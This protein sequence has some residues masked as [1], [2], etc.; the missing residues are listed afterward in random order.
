MK[1]TVPNVNFDINFVNTHARTL[2]RYFEP[3]AALVKSILIRVKPI[4][5]P[6]RPALVA[7]H[8]GILLVAEHDTFAGPT[9]SRGLAALRALGLLF[10]AFQLARAAC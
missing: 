6:R 4:K 5:L 9:F 8:G 3:Y 2:L 7:I 1:V 10:I